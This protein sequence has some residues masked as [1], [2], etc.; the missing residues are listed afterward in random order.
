[1]AQ[2]VATVTETLQ[3]MQSQQIEPM[4][5]EP[6]STLSDEPFSN[7]TPQA[8]LKLIPQVLEGEWN[9]DKWEYWFRNSALSPA[10][11]ELAQHGVMTGQIDGES[12]FHIPP[13]Y[14]ALL[15]QTQHA[16]EAE[17]KHQW[18]NSRFLVQYGAVDEITPFSLQNARKIK[19]FDRASVMLHEESVVKSLVQA[20]DA[21]LQNIQLKP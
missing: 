12:L 20:F 9:V 5:A 16:L 3:P 15:H 18:P 19:A 13:K 14:E 11:Q 17:L 7:Q 1:M 6:A 21:D 10:V 2:H 4:V 8:L